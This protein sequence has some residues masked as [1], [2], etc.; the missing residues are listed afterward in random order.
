MA[1]ITKPRG[2]IVE[3]PEREVEDSLKE[4]WKSEAIKIADDPF[5]PVPKTVGTLYELLPP[6]DSLTIVRSLLVVEKILDIEVPV[7]LVKTGG[8]QSREEML[9][10]LLPKLRR[11]FEKSRS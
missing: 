6:L 7:G 11:L 1:V 4:W 9:K 2:P 5:A 3:F 8:Y 10:D